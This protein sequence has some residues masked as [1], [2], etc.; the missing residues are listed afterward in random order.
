MSRTGIILAGG[1]SSR[2]GQNKALMRMSGVTVIERI[3]SELDKIVDELLI[4]TNS[5][6]EYDFLKIQ[7]VEDEQKG[8]GP[9]AGIQ[10]GLKASRSDQNLIVA[11]DMPFISTSLGQFLLE[12]LRDYQAAIPKLDGRIHPLFGAYHKDVLP[13]VTQ[14]LANNELRI[15]SLLHHVQVKMVTEDMLG[16]QGIR[17]EETAVFNMN[18]QIEYEK[19]L[20]L[21]RDEN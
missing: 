21:G 11:C 13:M 15:Q 7:L 17:V 9:L 20:R 6:R 2:M 10:A 3:A 12:E 4:V 14:C 18:D 8:K 5:L 19:A 16:S 1:Q